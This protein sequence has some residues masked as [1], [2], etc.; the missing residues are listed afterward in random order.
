VA[1]DDHQVDAHVRASL[2]AI[3]RDIAWGETVLIDDSVVHG[4]ELKEDEHDDAVT[5]GKRKKGSKSGMMEES[6]KTK[7]KKKSKKEK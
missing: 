5:L 2:N 1:R 7:I 3:L 4:L 6:L